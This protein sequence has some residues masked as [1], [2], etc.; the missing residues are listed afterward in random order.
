MVRGLDIKYDP[1]Q[2][3][4]RWRAD[5]E[6]IRD[7]E[8]ASA[9]ALRN[10]RVRWFAQTQS[11]GVQV[12]RAFPLFACPVSYPLAAVAIGILFE[13]VPI[14]CR[15]RMDAGTKRGILVMIIAVLL[16]LWPRSSWAQSSQEILRL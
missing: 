16:A 3:Y 14:L 1:K 9:I 6:R 2:Q 7:A 11:Y 10:L 15:N 8:C 12:I 5:V 13:T 4:Y